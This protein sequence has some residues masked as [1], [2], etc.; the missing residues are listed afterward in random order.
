MRFKGGHFSA[1]IHETFPTSVCSIAI[2]FKKFFMDEWSG[3]ADLR[4]VDAIFG[5]LKSTLPG[6]RSELLRVG[7]T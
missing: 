5:A 1:W 6:V 4:E 7:A 2:E 3:E